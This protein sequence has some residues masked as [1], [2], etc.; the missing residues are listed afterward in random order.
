MLWDTLFNGWIFGYKINV[1]FFCGLTN[2]RKDA[3]LM[4]DK[5]ILKQFEKKLIELGDFF[6]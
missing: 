2:G 6:I 1:L 5:C 3:P 4:C